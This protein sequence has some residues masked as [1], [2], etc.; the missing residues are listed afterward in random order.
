MNWLRNT[1]GSAMALALSSIFAA[2]QTN[3]GASPLSGSKGGTNNA[4]M[5]FTGPAGSMKTYVLPN[6]SETLAA[7]GQIQTW[8]GAQSF[9]DGKLILLGATS[10]SAIL[11]APATGGGTLTLPAGT[12]TIVALAAPQTMTNKTLTVP[13]INGGALAAI[14]GLGIRSTGAG[15]DIRFAATEALTADRTLTWVLG[16]A[17]RQIALGG[18]VAIGGALTFSGAFSFTGT[19]TGATSVTFPTAGTLA[20][21]AG[22]ETLTNKTFVCANQTSCI[23]RLGNDVTGVLP[24]GNGG[25]GQTTTAAARSSSGLNVDSFTGHGDSNYTILATDRTVGTNAAFTAAR[26]WTLPAANG[27]NPGQEVVIAD[28]QGTVTASNTLT[29]Q[30]AGSDTVNGGSSVTITAANGAY[31]FKSDGVSKWTAQALG[32]AS[33]GGVSSVTCGDGLTGGIITTSGTCATDPN[34]GGTK[35]LATLTASNSATLGDTTTLTSAWNE[36][37]LV[38]EDILPATSAT[39]CTFQIHSGGSFQ[40]S[41]YLGAV[42]AFFSTTVAASATTSAFQCGISSASSNTIPFNG[43][44]HIFNPAGTSAPKPITGQLSGV[45]SGGTAFG[46]QMSGAWNGNGAITGF[47]FFQSSGNITSGKI[48]IYGR[49]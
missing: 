18:N 35:L 14:T 29:I 40:G 11:K 6:A 15:F 45:S 49:K 5:Q 17:S 30:R 41:S 31:L 19:L 38:L 48:K 16:D 1:L 23:V 47:Q 44:I 10:G 27:V 24:I 7:L 26:T 13:T 36:Y 37:I 28:Y 25:T 8:T 42:L 9:A 4:F 46:I 39:T 21:I 12:D 43:V 32:A 22:A 33:G 20:T 3:P 2:A 34:Y